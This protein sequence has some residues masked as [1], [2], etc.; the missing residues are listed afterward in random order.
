MGTRC[1]IEVEGISFAKVY[2]HWDGYPEAT[3]KWLEVFNKRF[4]ENRGDDPEY[5]FAQ[6]L[7][8]SKEFEEEFN[9]DD[10]LYTGWGVVPFDHPH[11]DYHYI[12][13]PDGTVSFT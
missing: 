3:L 7:R 4:N 11:E 8:S 2:K 5:K 9:L 10:N 1:T 13:H 6:L 12:L